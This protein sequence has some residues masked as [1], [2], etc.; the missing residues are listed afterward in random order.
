[1]TTYDV[2]LPISPC[3]PVWPGDVAPALEIA[4]SISSGDPY[5]ST[6]IRMG[7]HTGT[8]VDAPSHFLAKGATVDQ[9]PL[10][11][12]VGEAWVA[13]L[14]VVAPLVTRGVLESAGIPRGTRR[15]LLKTANSDLW[16]RSP[17]SFTPDYVALGPDAAEWIADRGIELLGIDYLSVDPPPSTDFTAHRILLNRGV[18]V[19]EGLDLRWIPQGRYKLCCLP[20]RIVGAEGA[21]A[22]VV[23]TSDGS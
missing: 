18:V 12:L 6:L 14:P 20:L 15:L 17:C 8:H 22:R 5:N 10:E 23:L 7:S 4:A 11:V 19:V 13:E 3:L 2:T 21:P 9:L 1:M 16:A